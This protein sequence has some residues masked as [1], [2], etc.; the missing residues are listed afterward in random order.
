M[1]NFLSERHFNNPKPRIHDIFRNH[2]KN[3]HLFDI[4]HL[5]LIFNLPLLSV[6]AQS[7]NL[8]RLC[9]VLLKYTNHKT[10]TSHMGRLSTLVRNHRN[11]ILIN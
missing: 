1:K 2:L 8:K 9:Y 4:F 3:W 11:H 10:R 6:E 5:M 7:I